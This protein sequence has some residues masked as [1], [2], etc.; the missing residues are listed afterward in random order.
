MYI[1]LRKTEN[2]T[3]DASMEV[4]VEV[5]TE[6]TKYMLLSCHQNSGQNHNIKVANRFFE[7]VA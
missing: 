2:L 1:P 7:N 6:K 4:S 5:N 3:I